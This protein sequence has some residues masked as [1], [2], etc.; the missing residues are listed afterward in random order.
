[1]TTEQLSFLLVLQAERM[2]ASLAANTQTMESYR[3]ELAEVA[4]KVEGAKRDTKILRRLTDAMELLGEAEILL[5][6]ATF[7]S[8]QFSTAECFK[9]LRGRIKAFLEGEQ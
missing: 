6:V 4:A 3:R 5:A 9:R 7:P 8:A 1:M 2:L